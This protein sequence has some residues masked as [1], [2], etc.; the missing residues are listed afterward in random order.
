MGIKLTGSGVNLVNRG[1][2]L[3]DMRSSKE[4][5][6]PNFVNPGLHLFNAGVDAE[7]T[8][9]LKGLFNVNYLL[10]DTTQPL[11]VVLFQNRVRDEIGWD[12]SLGFRYRPYLNNNVIIL[13]GTAVFFPGDGFRDI[14]AR[15]NTLFHSFSNVILTF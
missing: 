4:E 2:L 6:Q 7:L 1:S 12:L 15:G 3:P 8:P 9:K 10:F 13:V 5:G 14:Y 11:R